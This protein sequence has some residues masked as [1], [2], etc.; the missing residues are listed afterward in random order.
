MYISY[1]FRRI[2]CW[3][4]AVKKSSNIFVTY[5]R[6]VIISS[7]SFIVIIE[8]LSMK[9]GKDS[10]CLR[11]GGEM[12]TCRTYSLATNERLANRV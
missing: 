3:K 10:L 5:I 12:V 11:T 9:K 7:L 6:R 4:G 2:Y 1:T 8:F